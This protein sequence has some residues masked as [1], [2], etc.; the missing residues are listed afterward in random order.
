[1][2]FKI[3]YDGAYEDE[4]I[5]EGETIEEIKENAFAETDR[6]GWKRED[7]WSERID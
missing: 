5:V 4:L 6:R 2:K 7:C 1:M 3:H